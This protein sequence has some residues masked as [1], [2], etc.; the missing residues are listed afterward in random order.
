[1]AIERMDFDLGVGWRSVGIGHRVWLA[2]VSYG[3]GDAGGHFELTLIG[4]YFRVW[5]F[6]YIEWAGE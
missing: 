3:T 2:D 1:M 4:F 5:F 6:K